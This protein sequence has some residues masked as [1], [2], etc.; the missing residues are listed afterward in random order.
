MLNV[1]NRPEKRAQVLYGFHKKRVDL[2]LLQETHFRSDCITWLNTK[3]YPKWF[4]ST[5]AESETKGV[6][7]VIHKNAPIAILDTHCDDM[8]RYVFF[9]F[10]I[11]S[12]VFTIAV[13]YAPNQGQV[14]FCLRVLKQYEEFLDGTPIL[15]ADINIPKDD[16]LDTT[17]KPQVPQAQ[18]RRL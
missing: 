11:F 4:H 18:R 17:G 15:V 13:L 8:G 9:K 16:S 12:S 3:Y 1:L 7:I 14:L 10:K 5:T 6:S 2:L